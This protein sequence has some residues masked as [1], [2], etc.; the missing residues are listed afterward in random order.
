MRWKAVSGALGALVLSGAGAVPVQA[1]AIVWQTD[2][3]VSIPMPPNWAITSYE[4]GQMG[5]Y[6]RIRIRPLPELRAWADPSIGGT[7]RF[8]T[9]TTCAMQDAAAWFPW[10]RSE[11]ERQF[12]NPG[13]TLKPDVRVGRHWAYYL[14][15]HTTD[16]V[17]TDLRANQPYVG[18][19]LRTENGQEGRQIATLFFRRLG[20]NPPSLVP[21]SPSPT[22]KAPSPTGSA[23]AQWTITYPGQARIR[24][25]VPS[26]WQQHQDGTVFRYYPPGVQYQL[27]VDWTDLNALV[28]ND[29]QSF[30][31]G[32]V[33]NYVTTTDGLTSYQASWAGYGYRGFVR[34]I[35]LP[36][37]HGIL[38][39][40]I[41]D[42]G[43]AL[44]SPT[45]IW[46]RIIAQLKAAGGITTP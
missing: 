39:K 36:D 43:T 6:V 38:L 5:G 40:A 21:R 19:F 20:M 35:Q 37:G 28:E 4:A 29:L 42:G 14:G 3:H 41:I 23:W 17:Y 33:S 44:G 11:Y 24:F 30:E 10:Y 34:T 46:Q 26:T 13:N 16:V 15:A 7:F 18:V 27:T 31:H 45:S 1:A 22:P 2:G 12:G 9:C 8:W 25:E 32:F